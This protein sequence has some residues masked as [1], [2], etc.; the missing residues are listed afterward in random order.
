M[1]QIIPNRL[2]PKSAA[3]LHAGTLDMDFIILAWATYINIVNA[4][5]TSIKIK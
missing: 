5:L 4:K 1:T 2:D 3:D